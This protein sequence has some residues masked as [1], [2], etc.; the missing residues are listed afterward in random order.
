MKRVLEPELMEDEGQVQCYAQANFD[1]PHSQFITRLSHFINGAPFSGVALD[2][3]CGPGDISCRF[4]RHFTLSKVHAVDGSE[5]MITMAR[6]QTPDDVNR[7]IR[8]ILGMLPDVML[9]QSS[10]ELIFSNSLLH[11]L[12]DPQALWQVIKK[13]AKPGTHVVIMD[14]LRPD[15]SEAAHALVNTYA[16]NEPEILQDD[17]YNSLLAAFTV[18]EIKQQLKQAGLDLEIEQISDRHV[19]ISGIIPGAYF[20]KW[21]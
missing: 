2:L 12:H 17:F 8:Y 16:E 11:H 13:Y 4:A 19:F 1:A 9:P 5:A 3:G 18:P 10:Y 15:S 7:R 6:Q 14:L 20:T 21:T